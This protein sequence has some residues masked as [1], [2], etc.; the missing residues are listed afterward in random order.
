MFVCGCMCTAGLWGPS[1]V[2]FNIAAAARLLTSRHQMIPSETKEK[3]PK[4]A[5][6]REKESSGERCDDAQ[7]QGGGTEAWT[8]C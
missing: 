4:K 8:T 3:Y 6:E 7:K 5:S 1:L 2:R